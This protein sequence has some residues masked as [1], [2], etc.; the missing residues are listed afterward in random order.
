MLSLPLSHRPPA[1]CRKLGFMACMT[2][3]TPYLSRCLKQRLAQYLILICSLAG[4]AAFATDLEQALRDFGTG[5]YPAALEQLAALAKQHQNDANISYYLARSQYHAGQFEQASTTLETLIE[6]HPEHVEAHYLMG[7]VQVA[8]V[9]NVN[10]FRKAGI[11]K[12]GLAAWE[13]TVTLDPNHVEGLYAVIS[14][15]TSA[16]ALA[17]GDLG[18]ARARLPQLRDLDQGWAMLAEASLLDKDKQ[19]EDAETLYRAAAESIQNRAFPLFAL[20]NHQLAQDHFKPALQTLTIYEQRSH[21]WN[22]PDESIIGMLRGRILAAMGDKAGAQTAFNRA[23]AAGPRRDI[24][25]RIES[26][27]GKL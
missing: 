22:D 11:A 16:P 1:Q 25:D 12:Q 8:R 5:R 6:N 14:Y 21:T 9:G 17:G 4:P 23:L 2:C 15:Y 10:I 7:S 19:P 26:E 20:A 18:K 13:Q 24:K 3:I 27:I